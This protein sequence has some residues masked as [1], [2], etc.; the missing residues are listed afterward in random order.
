MP[1][2]LL[3]AALFVAHAAWAAPQEEMLYYRDGVQIDPVEV[4]RILSGPVL[5]R[6][7]RLL[8]EAPRGDGPV[9]G[10]AGALAVSTVAVASADAAPVRQ[11]PESI[12][13]PVQFALDSADILPRARTQL[14]AVAQGIKLMPPSAPVLIEGHTDALGTPNTTCSSRASGLKRSSATS[15]A[16]MAWTPAA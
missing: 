9:A 1:R 4:S 14:D 3:I 16:S 5:K 8:P 15:S 10:G 6:S 7:I 2:K 13:L 12:A 11:R